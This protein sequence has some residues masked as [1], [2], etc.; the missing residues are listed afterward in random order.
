[1]F[2]RSYVALDITNSDIRLIVVKRN[3]IIKW[4][5]TPLPDNLIK[6][7]TIIEPRALGV[8]IDNLFT[9][10]KL[11]RYRVMCILTGLPFIYRTIDLPGIEGKVPVEAIERESR[12]EMSVTK[13]DMYLSWQ[14]TEIHTD[15]KETDFFVLGIPKSSLNPLLDTLTK[16]KIKP[17]RIEI[18]PLA[19]ARAASSKDAVIVSLEK[20]YYDIIIIS[21]G[22]VRVLHSVNS[23]IDADDTAGIVNELA[24]EL[25]KTIK[26][27]SRDPMGSNFPSDSPIFLFGAL[28]SNNEVLRLLEKTIGRS[29]G[30]LKPSIETPP[31]MPSEL[32]ASTIGLVLKKS[33]RNIS[34]NDYHDINVNLLAGLVKPRHLFQMS[35]ISA[36]AICLLSIALLYKTYDIKNVAAERT[37]FL[38]QQSSAV[39]EQLN[40]TSQ[41]NKQAIAVRQQTADKLQ[42]KEKELAKVRNNNDLVTKQRLDFASRINAII[43]ALPENSSFDT[44][45]VQP[46]KIIVSG[47]TDDAFN[48]LD[49][50]GTLEENRFFTTARI[51]ELKPDTGDSEVSYRVSISNRLEK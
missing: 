28:A 15:N 3:K 37:A 1:M 17:Y 12:R 6:R 16:A 22:L 24:D 35:H 42:T 9:T 27:F 46:D 51:E 23:S 40:A 11:A 31:E 10:H 13:E 4:I 5:S 44:I 32:F 14:A 38:Q 48:I 41:A 29:T 39:A 43:D 50:T 20:G 36:I 26:S 45:E 8:I 25:T 49:F 33:N 30:I 34:Y 19:L 18:K 47:K 21:N 7:G 2:C